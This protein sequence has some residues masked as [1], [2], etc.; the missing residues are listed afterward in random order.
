MKQSNAQEARCDLDKKKKKNP[1][2]QLSIFCEVSYVTGNVIIHFWSLGAR[3]SFDI[4]FSFS[5]LAV[6]NT[7]SEGL[8]LI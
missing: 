8:T 3:G 2:K 1:K 6:I 5:I 7:V 4:H